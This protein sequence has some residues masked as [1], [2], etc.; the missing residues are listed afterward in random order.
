LSGSIDQLIVDKVAVLYGRAAAVTS[1]TALPGDASTRR[2]YRVQLSGVGV[3]SSLMTMQLPVGSGLP[4]S[5]EELAVFTEELKELPFLNVHRFLHRIGVRVPEL[6]GQ[7]ETDGLLFIEDLGDTPLWD[8]VQG[9][10]ENQV[11]AWYK[12][13]IDELLRLQV[14]GT[15]NRDDACLAFQQR[16]DEK[17]YLWELE[18]FIEWGLE[19]RPGTRVTTK[20]LATLRKAFDS[21]A[22]RL[23]GQPSCLSHRDYH[24]WNLMIHADAVC[25]I[26]FQDALLAPAQYDLASLLNDRITDAVV[27]PHI[28]QQLV[29]YYLQKSIELSG[30]SLPRG[31][32]YEIYRLS[33]IQRDLKVVGRFYFLDLV[34]GKPGYKKFIP[35]TVR[36][37]QRNLSQVAQTRE[38]LPL[39]NEH[40]E[41]ML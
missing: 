24:S 35:P 26:D 2:Y 33:A 36:R 1:V 12:K 7:W 21:I 38:I 34:K 23:D 8:R 19:K 32:F 3:P 15:Q 39:L 18:H 30:R 25:V 6:Y 10:S 4:I 17:L 16:F 11:I 13:A 40:F 29:D 41:A 37:L 27:L 9:L 22:Q 28:E 31:Q 20:M 5:S 14:I